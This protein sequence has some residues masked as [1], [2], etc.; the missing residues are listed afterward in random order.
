MMS[1]VF[2]LVVTYF[3]VQIMNVQMKNL[4]LQAQTKIEIVILSSEIVSHRK[5]GTNV[6]QVPSRLPL[7][8][9]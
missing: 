7:K 2:S 9:M 3:N 6:N 8:T 1:L 5:C 4:K